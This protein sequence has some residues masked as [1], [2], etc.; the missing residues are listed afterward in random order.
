MPSQAPVQPS[1]VKKEEVGNIDAEPF[2]FLEK[3]P[4]SAEKSEKAKK[5]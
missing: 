1:Q 2:K 5:K 4:P 3:T